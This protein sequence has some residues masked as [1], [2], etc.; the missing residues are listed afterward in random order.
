WETGK[1]N[2]GLEAYA[3]GTLAEGRVQEGESA[4]I[5][6]VIAVLAA[7][8]EGAAVRLATGAGKA[9]AA[10]EKTPPVAK[11][12]PA[13]ARAAVSP[14]PDAARETFRPTVVRRAEPAESRG[15]ATSV[16]ASPLARRMA[17]D[18][19]LDL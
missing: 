2:M 18:H 13:A 14:K 7:P 4:P 9:A 17:R 10:A 12:P 1:A 15:D 6:A 5:G 3:E 11:A 16:K 8:G 19:D